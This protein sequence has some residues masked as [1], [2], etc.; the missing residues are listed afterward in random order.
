MQLRINKKS[1]IRILSR[2]FLLLVLI[3]AVFYYLLTKDTAPEASGPT[4]VTDHR[5][6]PRL[7]AN[8]TLIADGLSA[9]WGMDWLPGGKLLIT[10]RHGALIQLSPET[11]AGKRS[12]ITGVPKVF[13][14]GQGGL[15]DVT[16]HPDFE[17]NRFIYLS[18]SAGTGES[19]RLKILRAQFNGT[20]LE[21]SEVIFEVAQS[22]TGGQHY[23]SRFTWLPDGTLL[24]SIG[25]GGNPPTQYKGELIR[26]QAQNLNAHFGK[27]IR[28]HDDGRIPADNPFVGRPDARSEIWS[29][30]HRNIQGMAYDEQHGRV[31]ASEHGSKGGDEVNIIT[32]GA[33]YGWPLTTYS[34]EYNIWGSSISEQQSLPDMQDPIAVWTPSIAPSGLV[35]YTG[36]HYGDW[37]DS[38]FLA[39]M[40]L[41]SDT[42]IMAY[43]SLPAGAIIRMKVDSSGQSHSQEL[44]NL[45]PYR[46]RDIAQGPDDF[47]YVL[48][49]P[50]NTEKNS[51]VKTGALLRIEPA[52]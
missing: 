21:N 30:G 23:G 6:L 52:K 1:I 48:T 8:A 24:C 41:R 38:L 5:E 26:K 15:L 44:I 16:V 36:N 27:I 17:S 40:V 43:A 7:Q 29:L 31:F 47:L 2:A 35:Y 34:T 45:G 49:T 37:Q 50:A 18:Y 22:K 19:N 3:A 13:A 51:A 11:G 9:P 20:A 28:I 33:N 4:S 14:G 32:A 25:D 42:S 46:I 39:A 12:V 10:E